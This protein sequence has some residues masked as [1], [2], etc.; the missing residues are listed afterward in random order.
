MEIVWIG[1]KIF[2]VYNMWELCGEYVTCLEF[3]MC[4]ECVERL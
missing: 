4:G 1:C 2:G 3:I